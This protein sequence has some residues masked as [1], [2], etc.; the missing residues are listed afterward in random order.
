MGGVKA[1]AAAAAAEEGVK[2]KDGGGEGLKAV[3]AAAE[4]G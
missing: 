2:T 3:A 1:V 4:R